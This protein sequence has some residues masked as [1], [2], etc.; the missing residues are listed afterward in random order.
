MA[1]IRAFEALGVCHTPLHNTGSLGSTDNSLGRRSLGVGWER[2]RLARPRTHW[3]RG[4]LVRPGV[5]AKM[6]A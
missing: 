5:R 4:R 2:G 3:E 6:S 1:Y